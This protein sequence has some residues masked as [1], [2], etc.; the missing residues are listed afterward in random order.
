[1]FIYIC[2]CNSEHQ[3]RLGKKERDKEPTRRDGNT[4]TGINTLNIQTSEFDVRGLNENVQQN[5]F[6]VYADSSL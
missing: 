3:Y 1:M 4:Q 2:M 6:P 5:E